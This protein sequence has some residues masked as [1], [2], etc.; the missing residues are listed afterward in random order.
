MKKK[1]QLLLGLAVFLLGAGSASAQINYTQGFDDDQHGWNLY[2]FTETSELPCDGAGALNVNLYFDWD[3]F[4]GVY[5]AEADS[6]SLGMSDG[7]ELTISFDY[8]ALNYPLS[9]AEP[10]DSGA[11]GTVQLYYA[12]DAA[13]PWVLLEELD[14]ADHVTSADCATISASFFPAAGEEVFVAIYTEYS[15]SDDDFYLFIDNFSAV[16][17]APVACA[18]APANTTV[19]TTRET[20]CGTQTASLSLNSMYNDG[21]LTFKW[22][23]SPD[24]VT[25]T[26]IPSAS[27]T[28]Y[29]AAPT[30]STWYRAVITCTNGNVATNTPGIRIVKGAEPCYCDV[31][32]LENEEPITLVNFATIDK[33]TPADLA[34]AVDY[35]DFTVSV[36]APVI[37]IG[38][39]YPIALEGNTGGS[40]TNYFTVFMDWNQNGNLEDDGEVFQ[41]GS[42]NNSTG[43]DG[44]QAIGSITVPGD[45]V[46]GNTRMR[47]VKRYSASGAACN[48]SGYGQAED[49]TVNV[50]ATGATVDFSSAT[51]RYYPNPVKDVL[52]L[53]SVAGLKSVEIFNMLGQQVLAKEISGNE[54]AVNM[55]SLTPGSYLVKVNAEDGIKNIKVVKQ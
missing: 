44:N 9:T 35:E 33:V 51:L 41:I 34:T 18:G 21:G 55:A 14:A 7:G 53:S 24:N 54:A 47:V 13:G 11:W 39:S 6:P 43:V 32:F 22:Q 46:I 4:D 40:F 23:S 26:D 8:K 50:Q 42:I 36:A 29:E 1:L 19:K 38:E 37:V 16:Q 45:A 17:A 10:T 52:N 2:E 20:V 15:F 12:Y 27:G 30:V 3:T 49:Y 31:S 5:E 28:S 48:T 25:Y